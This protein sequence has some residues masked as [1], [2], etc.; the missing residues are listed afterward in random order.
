[1]QVVSLLLAVDEMTPENGGM[2]VL[3]GSHLYDLHE[4]QDLPGSSVLG[5][6]SD[7]ALVAASA[8]PVPIILRPGDVSVHSPRII[9]G[10]PANTSNRRRCGLNI[11]YIPTT[12]KVTASVNCGPFLLRGNAVAGVNEW[13]AFPRWRREDHF[14]FKGAELLA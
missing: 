5:S 8:E 7:P 10:S 2:S 14:D 12:T 9:H 6:G 11:R 1:M 3:P 4:Q 13:K